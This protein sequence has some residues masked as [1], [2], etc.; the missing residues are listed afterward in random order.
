MS[1]TPKHIL[2]KFYSNNTQC[3]INYK[4]LGRNQK[5][6]RRHSL[7]AFKNHPKYLFT[8]MNMRVTILGEMH[9]PSTSESFRGSN[10]T[11]HWHMSDFMDKLR[12]IPPVA[13]WDVLFLFYAD[14]IRTLPWQFLPIHFSLFHVFLADKWHEAVRSK[15]MY[16]LRTLRIERFVRISAWGTDGIMLHRH[17][18]MF[19]IDWN[20]MLS[21]KILFCIHKNGHNSRSSRQFQTDELNLLPIAATKSAWNSH[22]RFLVQLSTHSRL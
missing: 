12:H 8:F 22:E 14:G 7:L 9:Y 1:L 15:Q 13:E 5:H 21:G 11:I 4:T 20:V 2:K 19:R 10:E 17:N 18:R 16:C 6:S 3:D